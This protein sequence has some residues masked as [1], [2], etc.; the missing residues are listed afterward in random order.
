MKKLDESLLRPVA[1]FRRLRDDQIREV[2]DLARP[3]LVPAGGEVFSEAAPATRFYLLLDGHVRVERTSFAGERVVSLHIPP[4]QLFGIAA[5]LGRDTY[6]ATATAATECLV[7]WWPTKLWPDF[8]ARY[9]GFA[10]EIHR[11]VG[12]RFE[13]MNSRVIEL[14]T[15]QVEQRVASVLLRMARQNGRTTGDGIEIAFP[16]T[17]RI[18]SEMTG[19]TLHTVSRLLSAWQ[20]GGVLLSRHRHICVLDLGRLEALSLADQAIQPPP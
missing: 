10:D 7:L 15:Q 20:K 17:R 6:P 9:D 8:N 18:V 5:A 1:P 19:S 3:L 2:L 4:G 13:E 16:I 12:H 11:T 14:A